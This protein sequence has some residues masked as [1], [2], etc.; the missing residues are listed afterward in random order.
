MQHAFL[1]KED[2]S[3]IDGAVQAA[4]ARRTWI[5]KTTERYYQAF[6][7]LAKSLKARGQTIAALDHHALLAHAKTAH[8]GDK[9]ISFAL[10]VLLEHRDPAILERRNPADHPPSTKD[11]SLIEAAAAASKRP[12]KA[13]EASVKNLLRFAGALA[14]CGQE[15]DQLDHIELLELAKTA[16][17]QQSEPHPRARHDP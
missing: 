9:Q 17:S 16:V 14:G 8:E 5:P 13:V 2:A 1:S 3:L 10:E 15:I 6:H 11:K 4:A 12:K 7:R